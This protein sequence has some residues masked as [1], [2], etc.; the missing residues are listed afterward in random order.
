MSSAYWYGVALFIFLLLSFWSLRKLRRELVPV[1]SDEEGDVQITPHAL[2]ELVRKTC[3]DIAEVYS[4]NTSIIKKG[5]SL[6]LLVR[7]SVHADCMVKETRFNLKNKLE[8]VL[9]ENLNFS[10][11]GGVDIIIKGFQDKE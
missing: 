4:P 5:Q 9:V 2:E 3:E 11:F 6:R 8:T 1:F 10:N 7:L